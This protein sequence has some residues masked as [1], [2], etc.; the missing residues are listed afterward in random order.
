MVFTGM[1]N[2]EGQARAEHTDSASLSFW[3]LSGYKCYQICILKILLQCDYS[4]T[5]G[6]FREKD[7]AVTGRL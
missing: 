3:T 4:N 5:G 1:V 6:W 2:L 7:M